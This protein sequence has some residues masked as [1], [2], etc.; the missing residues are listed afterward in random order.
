MDWT[1]SLTMKQRDGYQLL[2]PGYCGLLFFATFGLR[3]ASRDF[4]ALQAGS[5]KA[6]GGKGD[7]GQSHIV[8]V[9]DSG[10]RTP[11]HLVRRGKL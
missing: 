1:D 2:A 6:R 4:A 10:A 9:G 5:L 3:S 8:L 11:K 7:R